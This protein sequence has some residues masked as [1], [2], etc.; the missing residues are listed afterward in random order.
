MNSDSEQPSL[1]ALLASL[2]V[3]AILVAYLLSAMVADTLFLHGK[4]S[5]DSTVYRALIVVYRPLVAVK[6]SFPEI[7]RGVERWR[8]RLFESS[9]AQ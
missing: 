2:A 8:L 4:I 9:K 6:T 7:D 3:P 1:N 5:P